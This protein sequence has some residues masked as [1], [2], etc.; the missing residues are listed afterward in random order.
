MIMTMKIMMMIDDQV[1]MTLMITDNEIKGT[2]IQR[3]CMLNGP[4]HIRYVNEELEVIRFK[5][6]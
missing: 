3:P 5:L 6:K 4:K 2:F 1:M